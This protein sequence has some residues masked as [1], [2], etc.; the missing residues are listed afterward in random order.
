[1]EANFEIAYISSEMKNDHYAHNSS[2]AWCSSIQLAMAW[3]KKL[4]VFVFNRGAHKCQVGSKQ[5]KLGQTLTT[6][7]LSLMQVCILTEI[8]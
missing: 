6:F 2:P 5:K 4:G 3:L 7:H 8:R 1:M